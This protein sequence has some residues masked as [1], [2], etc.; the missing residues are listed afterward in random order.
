MNQTIIWLIVFI[1]SLLV[2]IK[3]SDIFTISAE[4]IGK[5]LKFPPFI[6]GVTI[7]AI[8]TSLPEL[9]SSI[10]AVLKGNTEIVAGN[11]VGSNITNIFLIIGLCAIFAK[12]IKIN[13]ELINVDLP[14]LVGSSF[15]LFLVSLDKKITFLE[16]FICL[17]LFIVYLFYTLSSEQ[18]IDEEI[19]KELKDDIALKNKKSSIFKNIILLL[20]S[21]FLLYVSAKYTID[22]VVNLSMI[23]NIATSTIAVTAV[24]LGTSLP[25]LVVSI[26]AAINNKP[27]IAVGNILGSNIFNALVVIAI[28]SFMKNLTITNDIFIF[29][30]PAMLVATLLYFF[31]T[32]DKKITK[33]EG[34]ML[35]IFYIFFIIKI[36]NII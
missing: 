16:G 12:K 31:I 33:W 30:I 3:S 2:L 26:R 25:E 34:W 4:K 1:V 14:I 19:K 29:A 21:G 7:V 10:A 20:V 35:L 13:F 18:K 24:A 11:V 28:P 23:L 8:G 5:V 17:A 22:A 27:E 36:F 6:I 9:V 15:L 32:Q